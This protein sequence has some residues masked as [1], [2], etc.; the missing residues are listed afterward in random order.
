M[1]YRSIDI[2]DRPVLATKVEARPELVWLRIAD[3]IIDED[4]QRPLKAGS[5]TQIEKIA[6]AFTWSHFSPVLVAPVGERFAVIDGQHRTHAAKLVGLAEV[7]CMVLHLDETGQ[8]RAF[9]AV[10]GVV[11]T[12]TAFNVLR[13]AL[14]AGEPWALAADA[15]V[16]KAGAK[17]MTSNRSAN[18]KKPGEVYCPSFIADQVQLGRANVVTLALTAINGSSQRGDVFLWSYPFLRAFIGALVQAPRAQKR[19]LSAFID[20]YP[21]AKLHHAVYLLKRADTTPA[22]VRARSHAGLFGDALQEHLNR[23][24]AAGGGA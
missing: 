6:K 23:W 18:E 20:A 2:G 12:V 11:T 17:L 3:L 21:P 15:A 1:T 7:P 14:R 5:W 16:S 22:D 24:V 19:N 8:A 10:N 13:A 4:Y 9:A